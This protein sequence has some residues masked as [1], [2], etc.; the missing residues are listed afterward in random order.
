M[1]NGIILAFV[2]ASRIKPALT[3]IGKETTICCGNAHFR[4]VDG[5][6]WAHTQQEWQPSEMTMIL[7]ILRAPMTGPHNGFPQ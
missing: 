7:G 1:P 3:S 5:H 4:I 2:M 6:W